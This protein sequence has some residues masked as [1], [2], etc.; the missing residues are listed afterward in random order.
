MPLDTDDPVLKQLKKL[1][2]GVGLTVDRL[3]ASG[4]VMSALATSDPVEARDRLVRVLNDL[5]TNERVQALKVDFGLDL[6]NLLGQRPTQREL[7]WLGDRR[8]GFAS[9]V[10]RDVKTLARW[11][12]KAIGELRGKL[13]ADTFTGH[14]FVLA[15]VKGDRIL[16]CSM[17]Q[18]N[19]EE[20]EIT[21]RRSFDF[22]N[23]SDGPSLPCL[24]YGYPRDWRPASLTLAVS[25]L[26]E[27]H[28]ASVWGVVADSF[29]ELSFAKERYELRLADG[30]ATC[31]FVNPRRD[32]L[33]GMWWAPSSVRATRPVAD[34]D[35][36]P[37]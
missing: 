33:Y 28:P 37:P 17:V 15:G 27:P 29:L 1:R 12:D 8:S 19:E 36:D 11:S 14:L 34:D 3:K 30:V 13:L 22:K 10:G 18:Q 26:E 2:E 9:V 21:E 25:F 24:V 16:G 6:E 20:S 32:Q 23:P 35:R 4:A 7:A 5:G 31:R